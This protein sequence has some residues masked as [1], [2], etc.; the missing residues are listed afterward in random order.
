MILGFVFCQQTY[1]KGQEDYAPGVRPGGKN[2][3]AAGFRSSLALQNVKSRGLHRG[4]GKL[5]HNRCGVYAVSLVVI[6]DRGFDGLLRQNRAVYFMGRQ[7]PS[8]STCLLVSFK[9]SS[10]VL[11]LIISVAIELAAIA[12]PHP[13]VLNLTSQSCC[14]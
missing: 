3:A 6:R 14:L 7:P 2:K 13:N 10:I 8:A 1:A 5:A 12:E 11:P 9:A 4:V